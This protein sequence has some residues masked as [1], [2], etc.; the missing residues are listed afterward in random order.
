ME[1]TVNMDIVAE[2]RNPVREKRELRNLVSACVKK[3]EIHDFDTSIYSVY[4]EANFWEHT[5]GRGMKKG[6]CVRL[7][8]FR[9]IIDTFAS[10][11]RSHLL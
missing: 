2:T 8:N 10:Y 11:S 6:R 7:P 1:P 5:P 9:K 4:K 3:S